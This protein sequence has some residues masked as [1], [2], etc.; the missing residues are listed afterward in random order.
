MDTD[1]KD[2][3]EEI[4]TIYRKQM[5]VSHLLVNTKCLRVNEINTCTNHLD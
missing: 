5:C 1:D 2:V 4:S 3:G